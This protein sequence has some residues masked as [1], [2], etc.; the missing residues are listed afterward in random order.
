M[1][2]G[3]LGDTIFEVSSQRVLTPQS[4][5]MSREARF[6]EHQPQGTW[7][8]P[9]YMAPGLAVCSIAIS[10]RRDLGCDP[11]EEAE[12]LEEKLV[13]GEVMRLIIA[14]KNLGKWTLRKIDQNWRNVLK[15]APGPMAIT[16]NLEL[17]EYI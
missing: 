4:F 1:Q 12:K 10:L 9:E 6:E 5:G 16:L 3:S 11:F 7:P 15:N 2:V 14:G 17:K 13:R 8:R